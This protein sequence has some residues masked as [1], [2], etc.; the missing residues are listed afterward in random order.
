MGKK[1]L[2]IIVVFSLVG[3]GGG[4]FIIKAIKGDSKEETKIEQKK[5][6]K[7]KPKQM[8]PGMGRIQDTLEVRSGNELR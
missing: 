2:I 6:E 8:E 5:V 4:I 7:E 3:F 1:E